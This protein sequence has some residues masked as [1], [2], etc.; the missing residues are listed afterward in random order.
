MRKKRY[1]VPNEIKDL[2]YDYTQ[3]AYLISEN[4]IT[5]SMQ[6][7]QTRSLK[8][9]WYDNR[10]AGTSIASWYNSLK[11]DEKKKVKRTGNVPEEKRD[12]FPD[13]GYE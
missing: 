13:N 7:E 3:Q 4:G 10:Y 1:P 9:Y 8:Q 6:I 2:Y 5:Y 12:F 11:N